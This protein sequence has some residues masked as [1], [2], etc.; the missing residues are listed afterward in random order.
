LANK[1]EGYADYID[2][3]KVEF[4]RTLTNGKT[5]NISITLLTSGLYIKR[6]RHVKLL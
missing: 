6:L 4:S 1:E 2:R 3:R 5:Q